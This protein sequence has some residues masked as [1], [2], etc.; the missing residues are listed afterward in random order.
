MR[1]A[2]PGPTTAKP[3]FCEVISM[4]P[5]SRSL[6][7]WL[8]PRWPNGSL[9]VSRPT[10]RESSWGPRQI[11]E[12]GRGPMDPRSRVGADELAQRVDDVLERGRVAGAVGEEDRVRRVGDEL[13]RAGGAR[14]QLDGRPAVDEVAHDRGLD[15]G[16]DGRD[17]D[18]AVAV[19]GHVLRGYLARE[20]E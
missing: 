13:P 19:L 9:N 18:V 3:W 2:P 15:P 16:V 7:G 10:A 14:V 12:T 1:R 4:R 8:A 17:A 11:P 5:V 20:V 6:T